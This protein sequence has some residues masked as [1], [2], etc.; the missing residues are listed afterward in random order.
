[1]A[2]YHFEVTIISRGK[3]RSVTAAVGYISGKTLRD[4][5]S[6]K[7]YYNSRNDVIW[8]KIFLPNDAPQEFRNLQYLCNEIECAE[9]R[10][11]A[12]TARQ[13]IGSLPNELPSGELVRIVH[14]F[15]EDNFLSCSLCV[16]AAIHRGRNRDDP[17]R[18]TPHVHIIVPTRP[19]GEGGLSK[20][21]DREHDKREYITIWREQWA[22][23]QNRAYERNGLDI[24]VS[25]ETLEVQGKRDREP[26]IH[27]SRID[28]QKE[29]RGGRTPA[30]DRKRAIRAR[31]EERVRQREIKRECELELSR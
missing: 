15:I 7:T 27:L 22:E 28:W 1:M 23:V 10:R 24:Q 11:D 16:V 17:S 13:F 4:N 9:V 21:K 20:W 3:G 18:N 30:G 14:E 26:T 2:N 25:H 31:N 19:V 29:Q 6:S 8:Q 12:R 5:Y